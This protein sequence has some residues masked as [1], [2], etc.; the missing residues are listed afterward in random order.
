MNLEIKLI[1]IKKLTKDLIDGCSV[2][3]GGKYIFEDGLQNYM[4]LFWF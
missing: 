4:L 2:L 1:P 3:N